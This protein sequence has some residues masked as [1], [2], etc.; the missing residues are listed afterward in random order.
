[1]GGYLGVRTANLTQIQ[2]P[3]TDIKLAEVSLD[4]PVGI[5]RP[6]V[7][8][9]SREEID[10]LDRDD[11]HC[12]GPAESDR[13]ATNGDWRLCVNCESNF[14]L[15]TLAI[16]EVNQ[17]GEGWATERGADQVV[18]RVRVVREVGGEVKLGVWER[19]AGEETCK[20]V[21]EVVSLFGCNA[22]S[23]GGGCYRNRKNDDTSVLCYS[24]R[25]CEGGR[26]PSNCRNVDQSAGHR[27]R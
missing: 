25:S 6:V 4:L 3:S 20:A 21:D 5:L 16:L 2:L 13:C 9:D 23:G 8:V 7:L 24:G 15:D 27:D 17:G 1:M 18:D 11:A 10:S 26:R 14:L 19:V 22:D 12:R